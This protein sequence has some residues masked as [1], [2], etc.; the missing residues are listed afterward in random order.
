VILTKTLAAD[1]YAK[2]LESWRWLDLS[3]KT[4]LF[5]SLFGDVFFESD[6][7]CWFLD[8][9]EGTVTRR[10]DSLDEMTA[11]L[12]SAAGRD[13]YLLEGLATAA[14]ERGLVLGPDE[15]FDFKHPPTLGG[16]LEVDNLSAMDFAVAVNIAGQI[17]GQ[18]RDLPPGTPIGE[19]KIE[20]P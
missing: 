11:A 5:A 14:A 12:S 16:A 3:G 4:P 2:G 1:Q 17:H 18:I 7:G 9:V 8:T 6:E 19:I 10:W 13:Q 20:Q 15:V